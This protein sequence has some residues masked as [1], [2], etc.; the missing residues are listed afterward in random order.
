MRV[1]RGSGA[2]GDTSVPVARSQE[3]VRHLLMGSGVRGVQFAEDWMLGT[4]GFQFVKEKDFDGHKVPLLVRMNIQVWA[5]PKRR[6]R[7]SVR[8]K[9]QRERQVWRALYW[10]MKSQ[11]EAVAFGLRT[12]EDVFFSDLVMHDGRTIG[13]HVRG[14]LVTGRLALP[15]SVES[16]SGGKPQ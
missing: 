7:A 3:Q 5:D 4:I 14:A 2:Y 16:V 11:L 6:L 12:L 10:Y 13:D 15:E 8:E 1:S 9:L